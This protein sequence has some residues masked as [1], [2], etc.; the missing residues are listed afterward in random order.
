M[1]T[2]LIKNN[3][4]L[5]SHIINSANTIC[6][7]ENIFISNKTIYLSALLPIYQV[8]QSVNHFYSGQYF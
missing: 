7:L 2:G 8:S 3:T 5:I 6:I 1:L 4:L